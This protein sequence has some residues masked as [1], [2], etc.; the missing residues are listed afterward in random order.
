METK[1]FNLQRRNSS[2]AG[3]LGLAIYYENRGYDVEVLSDRTKR[4]DMRTSLASISQITLYGVTSGMAKVPTEGFETVGQAINSFDSGQGGLNEFL[5][6]SECLYT[7]FCIVYDN[8]K[9]VK[10]ST[11]S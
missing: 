4:F 9:I 7:H 3:F 2:Q 8:E 5:A 10:I 6:E 11:L 1:K